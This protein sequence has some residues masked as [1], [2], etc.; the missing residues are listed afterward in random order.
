MKGFVMQTSVIALGV[1]FILGS[2]GPQY[3]DTADDSDDDTEDG[4]GTTPSTPTNLKAVSAYEGAMLS[5]DA[6]SNASTY[7]I[8]YAN[9]NIDT[10]TSCSSYDGGSVYTVGS[11]TSVVISSLTAGEPYYFR[12]RAKN[13]A[14]TAGSASTNVIATPGLGLNDSGITVCREGGLVNVACP[15]ALF[16]NQDADHGLDAAAIDNTNG[17]A[18]FN[19]TRLDEDG[20]EADASASDWACAKDNITGLVWEVKL[21]TNGE[22]VVGNDG[23]HDADD[24]FTWYSTDTDSNAGTSGDDNSALDSCYGYD[25]SDATSYCNTS[26]FIERVNEEEY[27]GLSNWRLPTRRELNSIV[28]YDIVEPAIDLGVFQYTPSEVFWSASSVYSDSSS[29]DQAWA[30]DFN[31]GGSAKVDKTE[32]HRVRLVSDG[33]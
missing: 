10:Y 9:E 22:E 29:G 27:C 21:R 24:S 16:P 28:N 11:S 12:V 32:T 18:G 20:T 15:S 25:A 2:G 30:T 4:T 3:G 33:Q 5:W 13:S 6:T 17:H 23:L 14:G 8:C 1:F 19:F 26:A 7:E 31:Y